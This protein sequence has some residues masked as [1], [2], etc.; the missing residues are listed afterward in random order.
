MGNYTE[1]MLLFIKNR[2]R[3]FMNEQGWTM[4]RLA[5]TSGVSYSTL[6]NIFA[7]DTMPGI[8]TLG[9]IVETFGVSLSEFFNTDVNIRSRSPHEQLEF[10]E[11]ELIELYLQL[12][13][14]DKQ[15][16]KGYLAC[17]NGR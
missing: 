17:L 6:N 12:S 8:D 14:S 2:L 9:L 3:Q 4:Y 11:A 5:K 10:D 1:D 13:N 16:V 7:R 15:R